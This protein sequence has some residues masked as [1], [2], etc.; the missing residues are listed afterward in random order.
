MPLPITTR[1][2]SIRA[3]LLQTK[4]VLRKPHIGVI[5]HIV[6]VVLE[7]LVKLLLSTMDMPECHNDAGCVKGR[8]NLLP[9]L[10]RSTKQL[11]CFEF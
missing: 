11:E 8:Y 3:A 10:I 4:A 6:I 5:L 2:L 7:L 1:I 9:L